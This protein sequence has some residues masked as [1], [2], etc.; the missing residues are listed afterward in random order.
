MILFNLSRSVVCVFVCVYITGLLSSLGV[1]G[2]CWLVSVVS[3]SCSDTAA[4]HKQK[5]LSMTVLHTRYVTSS[6]ALHVLI[7]QLDKT[8]QGNFSGKCTHLQA[9]R[10]FRARAAANSLCTCWRKGD[11]TRQKKYKMV[12]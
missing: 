10:V 1:R 9:L 8:H 6:L 2:S 12:N 11:K 3:E 7:T 5:K 4:D